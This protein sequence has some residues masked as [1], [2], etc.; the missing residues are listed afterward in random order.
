MELNADELI[1]RF[2]KEIGELTSRAILAET[3]LA[4]SQ[5]TIEDLQQQ[6]ADMSSEKET[7]QE[8]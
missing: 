3:Q 2:S 6:I 7:P 5:K 8:D 4:Q 1:A